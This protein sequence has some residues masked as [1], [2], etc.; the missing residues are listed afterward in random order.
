[1]GSEA[2]H[3]NDIP[4]DIKKNIILGYVRSFACTS[5]LLLDYQLDQ[6]SCRDCRSRGRKISSRYV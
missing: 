4:L 3:F 1:M 5:L 2:I 6:Y